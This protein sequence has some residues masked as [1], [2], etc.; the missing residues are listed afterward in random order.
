MTLPALIATA[1][2][3]LVVSPAMVYVPGIPVDSMTLYQLQVACNTLQ[4]R[5]NTYPDLPRSQGYK[6]YSDVYLVNY[7]L[8]KV[9]NDPGIAY[10]NNIIY[11]AGNSIENGNKNIIFGNGNAVKGSNNY[12]FSSNFDPSTSSSTD[13]N[14]VLDDWLV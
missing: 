2:L 8:Q 9:A 14:L 6:M 1:L 10:Y 3:F 13:Q 5:L 4:D 12:V 7:F 11:G